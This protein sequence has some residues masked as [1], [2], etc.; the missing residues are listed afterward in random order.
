[1]PNTQRALIAGGVFAAMLLAPWTANA[2]DGNEIQDIGPVTASEQALAATVCQFPDGVWPKP[3]VTLSGY[4]PDV[5]IKGSYRVMA[6]GPGTVSLAVGKSSTAS[7]SL[8]AAVSVEA[9]AV[10]SK[11]S[12]T[13]SV[14]VSRSKTVTVTSSFSVKVPAKTTMWVEA[15]AHGLGYKATVKRISPSTCKWVTASGAV[16]YPALRT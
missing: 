12:A 7:E 16:K 9:S 10:F 14:S 15:G 3:V 1:M 6:T 5:Y 8:G 11:V 2:G 13:A 4:Q